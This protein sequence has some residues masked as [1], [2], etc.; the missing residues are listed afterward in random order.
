M[1]TLRQ[2]SF[3]LFDT[4]MIALKHFS[5]NAR[6]K[7]KTVETKIFWWHARTVKTSKLY[8]DVLLA[9]LMS[10]IAAWLIQES[11]G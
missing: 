6:V 5:V 1:G 7:I 9:F 3:I 2:Y 8:K 4:E 10:T 11:S